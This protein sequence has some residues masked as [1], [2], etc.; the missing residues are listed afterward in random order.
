MKKFESFNHVPAE[1]RRVLR[2]RFSRS[3]FTRGFKQH[4]PP[5]Q[6]FL[7]DEDVLN[8]LLE[9]E[10][11]RFNTTQ[12]LQ[13]EIDKFETTEG[14]AL[15]I[16]ELTEA[17]WIALG[18]QKVG[19]LSG[20]RE[21][22]R[23]GDVPRELK[24]VAKWLESYG[25]EEFVYRGQEDGK[26]A[27][28]AEDR[29]RML[30][31]RSQAFLPSES[32]V[33]VAARSW[34]RML[35]QSGENPLQRW[36]KGYD[37]LACPELVPSAQWRGKAYDAF[38]GAAF[39]VLE[40]QCSFESWHEYRVHAVSRMAHAHSQ[41]TVNIESQIP[42]IPAS[43]LDRAYWF[44][45]PLIQRLEMDDHGTWYLLGHVVRLL[46]DEIDHAD[47]S[48]APHPIFIRMLRAAEDR[49]VL[50]SKLVRAA[51]SRP[52]LVVELLLQPECAPLA[53]S[54]VADWMLYTGAWERDMMEADN[55]ASRHRSFSDAV[56]I[57]GLHVRRQQVPP[58]EIAA[59]LHRLRMLTERWDGRRMG[60]VE[61]MRL[62]LVDEI[63]SWERG[64]LKDVYQSL[65]GGAYELGLGLPAF[66]AALDVVEVGKL[67]EEVDGT[68]LVNAYIASVSSQKFG[69]TANRLTAPMANLLFKMAEKGGEAHL[70]MCLD[71]VDVPSVLAKIDEE[72]E[73]TVRNDL[74]RA[75]RSHIRAL[76]RAILERRGSDSGHLVEALGRALFRGAIANAERGRVHAFA[77]D[78]EIDRAGTVH[79]PG[80]AGD[81][82][83]A[84]GVLDDRT[85]RQLLSEIL[86]SDEPGFLAQVKA[87]APRAMRASLDARILA[88]TPERAAQ[89]YFPAELQRIES[90]LNAGL[91][92]AAATFLAMELPTPRRL[93]SEF[94]ITHFRQSLRLALATQD[95]DTIDEA[96]VPDGLGHFDAEVARDAISF[97]RATSQLLRE[98][99]NLEVG[100]QLFD[101]LCR[102]HPN[103]PEYAFN[104]FALKIQRLLNKDVFQILNEEE[105]WK[106]DELLLEAKEIERTF[107]NEP[108]LGDTFQLNMGLLLLASGHPS[109]AVETL[110]QTKAEARTEKVSAV[111][112][113]ALCR[114]GRGVAA[115]GELDSAEAEF[116]QTELLQ[117]V[118]GYLNTGTGVRIGLEI[119]ETSEPIRDIRS[120]LWSLQSMDPI[121]QA[122]AWSSVGFLDFIVEHVRN[123]AASINSLVPAMR[124]I[125]FDTCEDD[126]NM[127]LRELLA[128]RLAFLNWSVS[129]QSMGGYSGSEN[130]GRRDIVLKKGTNE[131][132]IGEA[133][134][135]SRPASTEWTKKDLAMHFAKLFAYGSC[136]FMVHLTYSRLSW[137]GAI[138]DELKKIASEVTVGGWILEK[139]D[140]HPP[141]DSRPPGLTAH[142]GN[143][144]DQVRVV[145]LVLD[146]RQQQQ[147]TAA[148]AAAQRNPRGVKKHKRKVGV[149]ARSES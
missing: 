142:Y 65:I 21:R 39:D 50:F 63:R 11:M 6:V 99:G 81:L 84:L 98:N 111:L 9:W 13:C 45:S 4:F 46:F 132:V 74:A 95:W 73:F 40:N 41:L 60:A 85:A 12:R 106:A 68:L 75:V 103:S 48:Q 87:V 37:L 49:P 5:E 79:E 118:R 76:A 42:D 120:A 144:I 66:L 61:A 27:D 58:A 7:K 34:E 51:G 69:H 1:T 133:L 36:I 77:L 119:S 143:G 107:R 3:L 24:P 71:P 25:H 101:V 114:S 110:Q 115:A 128:S 33:W 109:E 125:E 47:D 57:L 56:E 53:C 30:A 121:R 131:F 10:Q 83:R 31:N 17:G 16:S 134:I 26:I 82:G 141:I 52:H 35:V 113:V 54:L 100:E 44:S 135:C 20:V 67:I 126:L 91:N 137:N 88:L 139:L 93:P 32:P 94:W 70:R 38:I 55:Q 129:D 104:R 62:L 64:L 8:A 123:A 18:W 147:R 112:A 19:V 116:G 90:L 72:N 2:E 43:R 117:K 14:K 146:I 138:L 122:E 23:R 92:G 80:I 127:L 29:R 130:P 22:V 136:K 105:R 59:L 96:E 86:E 15:S 28:A 78:F 89:V 108:S 140:V 149:V 145:F 97:Y 102:K 124:G 148:K